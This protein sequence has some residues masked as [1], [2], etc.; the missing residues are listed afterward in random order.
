[1]DQFYYATINAVTTYY[2]TIDSDWHWYA[3]SKIT[4]FR[5]IMGK[6]FSSRCTLK[7]ILAKSR[8]DLIKQSHAWIK[9]LFCAF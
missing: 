8:H 4:L 6:S 9:L 2:I 5:N 3:S 7:V 1:M